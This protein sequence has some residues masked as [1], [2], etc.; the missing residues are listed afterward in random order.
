MNTE[1]KLGQK[2]RELR[3]NMGYTQFQLAELAGI[4][5]KHLSKIES[6]KHLPT[7]HTLKKLSDILNFDF[8]II[9]NSFNEIPTIQ[10]NPLYLKSIKILNSANTD[11]ELAAY[12]NVLKLANKLINMKK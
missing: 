5:D 9:D 8:R 1:N 4:D 7:Y 11:K 6:G 10:N 3:K 12:F 2:I